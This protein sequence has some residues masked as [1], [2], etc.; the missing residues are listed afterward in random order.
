MWFIVDVTNAHDKECLTDLIKPPIT[1]KAMYTHWIQARNCETQH[2][3]PPCGLIPYRVFHA[4]ILCKHYYV[5]I[6]INLLKQL[7]KHRIAPLIS[8]FL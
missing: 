6:Q 3:Y 8:V 5:Y 7:R 4:C 2:G 1:G